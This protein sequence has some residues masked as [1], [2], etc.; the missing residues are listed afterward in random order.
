MNNDSLFSKEERILESAQ[1]ILRN[2]E[3]HSPEE[4]VRAFSNLARGYKRLLRLTKNLTRVSDR[5]QHRLQ[6]KSTNLD[7]ELGRHVGQ[8]I[9][10]EILKGS[11]R[12]EQIRNQYLTIL[13]VDIRG[14]TTF[15]ERR[16]PDE[17]IRFLKSY[18]EYL[19]DIVH[20][21]RGFVKSFMGDGVMLVFGYNQDDHISNEPLNCAFEI[22]DRLSEFNDQ[23]GTS[24]NV[25]IGMHSGPTGAGN[26]GTLDRT[27]FAVIGNT[28]NMASR[29]ESETK[30]A[31][32]PLLFSGS[33]KD[34][35]RNFHKEPVYVN[36]IALRGQEE[37]VD[38][39][40]FDGLK[41]T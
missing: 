16:R 28:V 12:E 32:L 23:H 34:L 7:M 21:H 30:K 15:S 14:F 38:L 25:G 13:F 8:E 3:A 18:Y 9:K 31:N 20:R 2:P 39:F 22:L 17:V 41:D 37:W 10:A 36:T 27:E 19:L 40:T 6:T 33:V 1:E 24:V 5:H 11:G 26:I 4:L 29:I 35:L